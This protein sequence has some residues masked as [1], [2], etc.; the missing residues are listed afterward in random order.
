M[1]LNFIK[2]LFFNSKLLKKV[3][4]SSLFLFP[5]YSKNSLPNLRIKKKFFLKFNDEK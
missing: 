4:F 2:S 5:Y 1:S 3:I